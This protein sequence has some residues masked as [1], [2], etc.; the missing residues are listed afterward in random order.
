MTIFKFN[1]NP[2]V[3]LAPVKP[4]LLVNLTPPK[5]SQT[6]LSGDDFVAMMREGKMPLPDCWQHLSSARLMDMGYPKV[7]WSKKYKVK[8]VI[9]RMNQKTYDS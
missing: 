3:P 7:L 5:A 2:S 8:Y 1:A 4:K 6:P 9:H